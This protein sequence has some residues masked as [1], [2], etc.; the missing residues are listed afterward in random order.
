[1]TVGIFEAT[2]PWSGGQIDAQALV[3]DLLAEDLTG[4][5]WSGPGGGG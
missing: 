4:S 2:D 1:M 3:R 5:A